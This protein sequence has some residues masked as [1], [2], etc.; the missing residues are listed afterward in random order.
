MHHLD[1]LAAPTG[2]S[3]SRS[4][5]FIKNYESVSR[6]TAAYTVR[7]FFER[8]LSLDEPLNERFFFTNSS[9]LSIEERNFLQHRAERAMALAIQGDSLSSPVY[10]RAIYGK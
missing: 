4:F 1:D 7:N 8:F 2:A 3:D 5:S 9:Q 6:R 10:S